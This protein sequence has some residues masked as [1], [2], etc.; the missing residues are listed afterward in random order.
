[1]VDVGVSSM[2]IGYRV[3]WSLSYYNFSASLDI[4]VESRHHGTQN[5][6]RQ[7]TIEF[8][9]VQHPNQGEIQSEPAADMSE[10]L[11]LLAERTFLTL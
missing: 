11:G 3:R 10:W 7:Q 9:P 6:P 2:Y 1:M 8:A 5:L 4:A